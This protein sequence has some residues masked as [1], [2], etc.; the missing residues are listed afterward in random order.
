MRV[1]VAPDKF[2]GTVTALQAA[3]A[4]ASG[5]RRAGHEAVV[6][7]LADGGEGLLDV[8]GGPNRLTEVSGPLGDD[9]TAGWRYDGRRAVIEMALAS[10]LMLVGGAE[11]N[12]AVAASTYGTGELIAAAVDAGAREIIVG[13][14][15][16][17]TTDGGLGALRA[18]LSSRM[19]G[20]SI[21]VACDVRTTFVDAATTF[22][23]QKGATPA[24]VKLLQ[25]RLERLVDVYRTEHGVDVSQIVGGG[26]AG[27]LAGGLAAIGATLESGFELVAEESGFADA[28]ESA[29][30]VITGEGFVDAGS[31]DGK[32]VGGV[33]EWANE[34]RVPVLVVAGEVFELVDSP[35]GN[36]VEVDAIDLVASVGR[37][38]AL[39]DTAASLEQVVVDWF[40]RRSITA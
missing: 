27:G 4:M 38:R 9:V 34:L 20:V 35:G 26:A 14:G 11:G 36:S 39:Q 5:V 29:D 23:P 21:T 6:I 18:M 31:F 12:D 32:V 1:V 15:G 16:S 10:G 2:R 13:V 33:V 40:A 30:L 25:R 22:A 3:E 17:A 19:H 8:F 37:E 24:Q 7:P 28:I